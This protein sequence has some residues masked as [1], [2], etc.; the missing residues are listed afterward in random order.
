MPYG[1]SDVLGNEFTNDNDAQNKNNQGI[2]IMEVSIIMKQIDLLTERIQAIVDIRDTVKQFTLLSRLTKGLPQLS[3][4]QWNN[5][6]SSNKQDD[7][8][9]TISEIE[10][11]MDE[12]CYSAGQVVLTVS[13]QNDYLQIPRQDI[14]PLLILNLCYF[15]L[16]SWNKTSFQVQYNFLSNIYKAI[17]RT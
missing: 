1:S 15:T 3:E 7:D 8:D 6:Q 13:H 17:F 12:E 2:P 9:T 11:V 14:I 4:G 5:T 16:V 10:A